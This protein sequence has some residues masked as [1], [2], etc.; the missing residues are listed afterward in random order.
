MTAAAYPH[1]LAPLVDCNPE[2]SARLR[3][4]LTAQL[5]AEHA[6]A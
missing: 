5:Q 3:Q 2:L 6:L 1:L 4:V